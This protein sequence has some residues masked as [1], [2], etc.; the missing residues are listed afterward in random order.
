MAQALSRRLFLTAF[1]SVAIAACGGGS[2]EA[3]PAPRVA[4]L[5]DKAHASD[6]VSARIAFVSRGLLGTRYRANTLIGGPNRPEQFVVR[7]D[8]FDCVTYCEA[9]L[10]AAL[11]KDYDGF[12][13][14]LRTI[15]YAN[16]VVRWDER[17]HY[18]ADW[19]RRAIE[20][21][22]CQAVELP[23]AITIDKTVNW[24][25]FGRRQVSVRATPIESLLA[26]PTQVAS[27]DI[28]GFASRRANLDYF[29]TGF[30]I[31]GSKGEL[32]LRHA[33]QSRGRVLDEPM[34]RFIAANN[35]QHVTLLRAREPLPIA[36]G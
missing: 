14:T 7:D 25:N 36:R 3:R 18:F 13:R 26:R 21:D 29:H 16:G 5:I 30:V 34:A 6:P 24:D 19:C 12:E 1:G 11:A 35:V 22:I 23:N 17:N 28:I 8:A 15:R 32:V 33:S 2:V 4:R 10:A 9:V 20:K 31:L 27:G